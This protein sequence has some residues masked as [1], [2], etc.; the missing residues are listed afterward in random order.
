[1]SNGET[2]EVKKLPDPYKILIVVTVLTLLS[3]FYTN[4]TSKQI[5]NLNKEYQ[6][7]D[8]LINLFLNNDFSQ[9]K[10]R[11]LCITID[12]LLKTGHIKDTSRISKLL[13]INCEDFFRDSTI[14]I[15]SNVVVGLVLDK[16]TRLPIDNAAVRF[17]SK[18]VFTDARGLFGFSIYKKNEGPQ[19]MV[20]E[21]TDYIA[22]SQTIRDF[23][24]IYR[25]TFFLKKITSQ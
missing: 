19:E 23:D 12:V 17:G 25:R 18:V 15:E 14:L 3:T 24:N 22:E 20:I 10:N 16:A 5:L 2:K 6:R 11:N 7:E 4:Y 21:K 8:D 13:Q 1:M 9:Q